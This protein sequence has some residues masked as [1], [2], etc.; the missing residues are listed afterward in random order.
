MP[1]VSSILPLNPAAPA[2]AA[3][4]ALA[5][6]V[7]VATVSRVLNG[8]PGKASAATVERVRRIAADLAYRPGRAGGALRQGRS[9]LVAVLAPNL[10]NPAMAAIAA[11]IE[12]ALRAQQQV[13]VLCDTHEDPA[14]QDEMLLEM[15]AQRVHATIMLGA[16][17]SPQLARLCAAGERILFVNRAGPQAAALG[18]VGIDN[19]AAGR[20]VA[21]LLLTRDMP[22]WGVICASPGSSAVRARVA[23]LRARL[24]EAGRTLPPDR[25]IERA[26][27]DHALAG[28]LGIARLLAEGVAPRGALFCTS[29]LVAY[30]AAR[31][32]R[33]T[34]LADLAIVGF[35]DNPLN[36]LLAPWLSSVRIPYAEFGPAIARALA[37]SDAVGSDVLLDFRL[38]LRGRLAVPS[39]SKAGLCPDPQRGEPL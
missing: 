10:A 33:E 17:A 38:V 6:G 13:M 36:D 21:E 19:R 34:T 39:A 25:I 28:Q 4:V 20:A 9:R 1:A 35:D 7:S 30:G 15:R 18:F 12:V 31:A 24:H 5:A 3:D 29:D 8:I 32:L 27:A 2:S 37:G 26:D 16:V 23:G 11:S 14:I 22:V